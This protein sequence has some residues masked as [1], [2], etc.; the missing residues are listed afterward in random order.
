MITSTGLGGAKY[1][2]I[3]QFGRYV[4][5]ASIYATNDSRATLGLDHFIDG[6][7]A[8][9]IKRC[10]CLGFATSVFVCGINDRG[11]GVPIL[12]HGF[13]VFYHG[14]IN[15]LEGFA[16]N[17]FRG[18]YLYGGNGV[19]FAILSYGLGYNATGAF[20]SYVYYCLGIGHRT[21]KGFG[22]LATR[23]VLALNVFAMGYPVGAGLQCAGEAGVYMGIW[24][25]SRYGIY[26]FGYTTLWYN[27]QYFWGGVTNLGFYRGVVK[28]YLVFDGAIF[29]N[30][31]QGYAGLCLANVGF[32]LWGGIWGALTFNE[33]GESC[34]IAQASASGG[35][36]G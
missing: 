25:P 30:G 23:G 34:A 15:S 9:G 17:L 26:A 13:K 36:Q 5:V 33:C 8:M 31:P 7:I 3:G 18:I 12:Y 24:F 11:I 6:G 2:T 1:Y 28:G 19:Y 27:N 16:I 29:G 10:G 35:F 20:Y 4:F 21:I 22:A 32:I 14:F